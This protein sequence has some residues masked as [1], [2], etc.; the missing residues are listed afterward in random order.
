M[1]NQID[2]VN[3]L[4]DMIDDVH[5]HLLTPVK[6]GPDLST[7]FYVALLPCMKLSSELV[8]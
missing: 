4:Y 7:A 8:S 6:L 5:I 2:I 1:F 3:Y